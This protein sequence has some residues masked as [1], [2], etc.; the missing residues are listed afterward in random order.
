M[1][2]DCA[3]PVGGYGLSLP[4]ASSGAG[5][6]VLHENRPLRIWHGLSLQPSSRPQFGESKSDVSSN[7]ISR[8]SRQFSIICYRTVMPEIARHVNGGNE[9][10]AMP[11]TSVLLSVLYY[12]QTAYGRLHL[13]MIL[14]LFSFCCGTIFVII[15]EM[16]PAGFSN[17][18]QQGAISRKN[19]SSGM[20]G[21]VET[22]VGGG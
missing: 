8:D 15:L 20:P 18:S 16:L 4:R 13:S 21:T 12:D 5:L 6:C 9:I 11:C 1:V 2:D 22:L 17:G 7:R 3:I 19:W 10:H 14:N